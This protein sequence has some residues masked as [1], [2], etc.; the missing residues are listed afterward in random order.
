MFEDIIGEPKKPK[1][2]IL[3]SDDVINYVNYTFGNELAVNIDWLKKVVGLSGTKIYDQFCYI[4][5]REI[6]KNLKDRSP[7]AKISVLGMSA[8]LITGWIF[9]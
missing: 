9:G 6:D 8:D 4:K 3:E 7:F 1:M 5:L 2:L